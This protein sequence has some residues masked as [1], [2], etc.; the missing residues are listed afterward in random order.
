MTHRTLAR[1]AAALMGMLVAL[2]LTAQA[3]GLA[4]WNGHLA[5]GY[6]KLFRDGA[7]AGSLS[8]GAGLDHALV[9]HWRAGAAIGYHLLGSGDFRRGSLAAGVDYSLLDAALLVSRDLDGRLGR[10]RLS[11]GPGLMSCHAELSTSGGG[12]AFTDLAVSKTAA[13]AAFE[14]SWIR[15]R[16]R[17]VGVGLESGVRL[18]FVPN[19]TWTVWHT[20]VAIYY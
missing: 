19:D 8:M 5:F 13:G 4:D 18:G 10:L 1:M 11:A 15:G 14:A 20:R 2:P 16:T 9:P 12:L 3:A 7:P 6:S 17:P